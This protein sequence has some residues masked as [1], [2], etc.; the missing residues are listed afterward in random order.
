MAK[1]YRNLFREYIDAAAR[2]R[3]AS[4]LPPITHAEWAREFNTK[5]KPRGER[6]VA[7]SSISRY[8]SNTPGIARRIG[9]D[10]RWILEALRIDYSIYLDMFG[11][12]PPVRTQRGSE[13]GAAADGGT[14]EM[15]GEAGK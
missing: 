1:R 2:K 8:A 4:G 7:E 6:A 12:G 14:A 3:A 15:A 13:E 9:M 10:R 11:D 5:H